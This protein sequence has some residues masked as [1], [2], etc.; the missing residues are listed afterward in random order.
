MASLNIVSNK[1]FV[2]KYCSEGDLFKGVLISN[3][4]NSIVGQY[5]SKDVS[6]FVELAKTLSRKTAKSTYKSKASTYKYWAIYSC[7]EA[8]KKEWD[9]F[10][11]NS[12][13]LFD[14]SKEITKKS[15]STIINR[16][17]YF[18]FNI[19][20]KERKILYTDLKL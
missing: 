20:S 17:G 15:F 12:S 16:Y 8:F 2:L 7:F 9:G 3:K 13:I 4:N 1:E 5:S 11:M 14:D 10:V 6:L 19:A 18:A